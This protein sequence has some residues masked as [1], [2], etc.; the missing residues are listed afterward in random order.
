MP[1]CKRFQERLTNNG[2][3]TTFTGDRPVHRFPLT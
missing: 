2:K 3:M 1:V